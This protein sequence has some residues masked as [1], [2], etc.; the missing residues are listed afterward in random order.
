MSLTIGNIKKWHRMLTGKSA[1]HVNQDMGKCFST[2]EVRGY[3]NNLTEKVNLQPKLLNSENLPVL[4]THD[5]MRV[6]FPVAIFQYGLGAYDLY[7]MTGEQRYLNKFMQCVEWAL[8]KQEPIGAWDNSSFIYPQNP[9]G[10]MAQGEGA[11]LLIRAYCQTKK[12]KYLEAA[13]KALN[14]ML[15]STENGG[16]TIHYQ[17]QAILLEYTNR[18]AVLNGWIFALFGLFDYVILTKEE[19]FYKE[20]LNHSLY[21]LEKLLPQFSKNYWSMYD[22]EGRIASPF[23]HRLHIAQMQALY[24][25]T[26]HDIFN[27]YAMKWEKESR[28]PIKK[29]IAFIYKAFQKIM[30]KDMG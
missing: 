15:K 17:E 27:E 21:T 10:A 2:T 4:I 11:S 5:G 19:T 7:L 26:G 18:K 6:S 14:L 23:Y 30:E 20:T 22:L 13:R 9:Y 3:Y 1:L 28:N 25:L 16:T 29:T 8:E 24:Q 12:E